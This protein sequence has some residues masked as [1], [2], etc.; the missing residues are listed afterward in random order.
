MSG[1]RVSNRPKVPTEKRKAAES[2][3]GSKKKLKKPRTGSTDAQPSMS[4][5]GRKAT[6]DPRPST[7]STA[8]AKASMTTSTKA[9]TTTSARSS[10]WRSVEIEDVDD[11]DE[12]L[13]S[14]KGSEPI[15]I[16]MSS[17]ESEQ[18]GPESDNG[19][20]DLEEESAEQELARMQRKWTA[21]VYA[22]F[23]PDVTIK[24]VDGR[25][26]HAFRCTN[27]GCKRDIRRYLNS[28]DARSTSN[29]RKHVK[30]CWGEEALGAADR[31]STSSK[32]KD[33]VKKYRRTQ[34][35]KV[36]F[37][38]ASKKSF[39][40]STIQHTP[41]ETRAEIVRWVSESMRP[42]NIVKDRGFNCLIKTGRPEYK[43]PS[44]TTVGRD[45]RKVFEHVRER[46]ARWLQEYDGELNFATD[47][48]TSP[49]QKAMVAFTVHFMRDEAP[50]TMVLDIVEVPVSHSGLN[51]ATA[52]SDMI[53][54]LK[55][56]TKMLGVTCDNA[57]ANDV[58]I[59]EMEAMILSFRGGRAR[60]RCFCHIINLVAKMVLRQFEPPKRKKKKDTDAYLDADDDPDLTDWDKELKDLM[61]DL[62]F[63]DEDED[64]P[65]ADSLDG[66]YDVRDDLDAANRVSMEAEVKP[67]KM[68]LLKL[69]KISITIHRS[70]TLL[71]PAWTRLLEEMEMAIRKLPRDVRTRWNSTFR[72]LEVA[73]EYRAAIEK[74]T[75]AQ[76][77]GLRKWELDKREWTLATQLRDFTYRICSTIPLWVLVRSPSCS[78]TSHV[79]TCW[80]AAAAQTTPTSHSSAID[81][82]PLS[83]RRL[84]RLADAIDSPPSHPIFNG[85]RSSCCRLA[86]TI[87]LSTSSSTLNSPLLSTGGYC[88]LA[89]IPPSTGG[90]PLFDARAAAAMLL[91]PRGH[92]P[93]V[94]LPSPPSTHCTPSHG[95]W[96]LRIMH[97]GTHFGLA[98]VLNIPF[99][100]DQIFYE[101]TLYFSRTGK[102]APDLTDVIPAMDDI[103]K[104]LATGSLNQGLDPAIRVALGLG[105]R[106]INHY[107][108]KSDES[109][110]YR[111]AM[112]LD[113][114]HKLQ[115]FRDNAWP[116][117]WIAQARFLVRQA[118]DEDWKGQAVPREQPQGAEEP[119]PPTD[120][121]RASSTKKPNM[122]DVARASRKKA[123]IPI[124][125]ELDHYLSTDAKPLID[126]TLTWW[127]S[128]EQRA[129]YPN[130]SR[131]AILYL[132]IPH[133]FIVLHV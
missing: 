50:M 110:V 77:N 3:T 40:Y 35:L 130:L 43:L 37:G 31:M 91:S 66:F 111:I 1:N 11:V 58:M 7:A 82:P 21:P 109:A 87:L 27:T 78:R 25:R 26:V 96:A 32:A 124:A 36:A 28:K 59:E 71:L 88:Q 95:A 39:H 128:R 106:S 129:T 22:F 55:L 52:F 53:H 79:D 112:V 103:D 74:M 70:T 123:A 101:A 69:R 97:H 33:S 18:S 2:P 119:Q 47:A 68:M 19:R 104:N 15:V 6:T 34:N 73:V 9:S 75:E 61:E 118:Y 49:N 113:P 114:R 115:Y 107:Y 14:R 108:N 63:D 60:S 30:Q 85:L 120:A 127:T 46:V 133:E 57:S 20:E 116:E 12:P 92:R 41:T 54:E 83:T 24:Y 17:S 56:D 93:V 102:D 62:D 132:T 126:N 90:C 100:L 105:K 125:D 65:G 45:V 48:W 122:F 38:A 98:A 76:A 10:T 29:L 121:Q 51:L 89:A 99:L 13:S 23:K 67:V 8:S 64:V 117:E 86:A 84:Y 72:M 80:L 44:P 5:S 42:F 94:D 16:E 81:S 131:M 4:S